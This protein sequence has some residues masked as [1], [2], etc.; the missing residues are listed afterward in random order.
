MQGT[1]LAQ[2]VQP[3]YSNNGSISEGAIEAYEPIERSGIPTTIGEEEGV[4]IIGTLRNIRK[5]QS[6]T[7]VEYNTISFWLFLCSLTFNGVVI[8]V[9]YYFV[10]S[11]TFLIQDDHNVA[12]YGTLGVSLLTLLE[13]ITSAGYCIYKRSEPLPKSRLT[14]H[15]AVQCASLTTLTILTCVVTVDYLRIITVPEAVKITLIAVRW[16]AI[17]VSLGAL[18]ARQR[19]MYIIFSSS[20]KV[21]RN[22]QR[23]YLG[24]ISFCTFICVIMLIPFVI[25]YMADDGMYRK[26]ALL[27]LAILSCFSLVVLLLYTYKTKATPVF[28][29]TRSNV[30]IALVLCIA[31]VVSYVVGRLVLAPEP[32]EVTLETK[33]SFVLLPAFLGLFS[34][35]VVVNE[36]FGTIALITYLGYDLR[37][38]IDPLR[39]DNATSQVALPQEVS[40]IARTA[41][42]VDDE[43]KSMNGVRSSIVPAQ[44]TKSCT[45]ASYADV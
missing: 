19:L 8:G 12:F 18:V 32:S 44:D 31:L 41:R 4:G 13:I 37:G 30:R 20:I 45:N 35:C 29:D 21:R 17:G 36:L 24:T 5:N 42:I 15:L 25:I 6:V 27:P 33:M 9:I 3:I 22:A 16:L 34:V 11:R 1:D 10:D 40:E 14:A 26:W 2:S 38:G 43:K 7:G 39:R 28:S 23:V